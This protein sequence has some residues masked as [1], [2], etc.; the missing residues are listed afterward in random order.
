MNAAKFWVKLLTVEIV[1]IMKM[2]SSEVLW[3]FSENFNFNEMKYIN[4]PINLRFD[5]FKTKEYTNCVKDFK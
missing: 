1:M 3:N 2:I 5:R 4:L